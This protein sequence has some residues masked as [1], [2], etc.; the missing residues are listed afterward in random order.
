MSNKVTDPTDQE[1]AFDRFEHPALAEQQLAAQQTE[2]LR[3]QNQR[4]EQVLAR[5]W[6]IA[7]LSPEMTRGSVTAQVRALSMIIAIEGLIPGKMTDGR[8][9]SAAQK[10]APPPSPV[11]AK[12][13]TSAW[14]R[15]QQEQTT[16]AGPR[17]EEPATPLVDPAQDSPSQLSIKKGPFGHRD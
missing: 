16:A 14:L 13:Y 6:E 2:E 4:R 12:I 3:Q 1:I 15:N 5:L 17:K 8:A 10:T 11:N 9:A 7:N